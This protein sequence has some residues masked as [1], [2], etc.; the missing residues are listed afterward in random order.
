MRPFRTVAGV[1]K[2]EY[3]IKNSR[4]YSFLT[5]VE[6]EE[7]AIDYR[8]SIREIVPDARHYV[9]AY[10]IDKGDIMRYSDAKE[11]H[12]TAGFPVFSVIDGLGLRDVVCVVARIFGG[13]LL[14]RGG[15]MRAYSKAAQMACE[16]ACI[17]QNAP[18]RELLA[19][20]PYSLYEA[21]S[22]RLNETSDVIELD[23][24]FAGDVTLEVVV[25]SE[26]VKTVE[27]LIMDM[28]DGRAEILLGD[29]SLRQVPIE[30]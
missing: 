24:S 15:L 30:T 20:I 5:H 12:G 14:G 28:C 27:K 1:S 23:A 17:V 6:S 21:I 3:E 29:E 9:S 8:H 4:F 11:P 10:I 7:A 22:K 25:L 26:R 19:S 16:S 2:A 13:T 18:C